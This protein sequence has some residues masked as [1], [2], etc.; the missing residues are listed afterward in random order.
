VLAHSRILPLDI[1]EADIIMLHGAS[2]YIGNTELQIELTNE[3]WDADLT[4]S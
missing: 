2:G 4:R 3:S 1:V